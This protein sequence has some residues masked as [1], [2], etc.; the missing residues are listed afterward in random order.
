MMMNLKPGNFR[1]RIIGVYGRKI[2]AQLVPV[3]VDTPLVH[4]AGYVGTPAASRKKN[5]HQFFFTNGRYM[6]HPYFAKAVLTAFER[7]IGEG[8]QVPFFLNFEVA[9][10]HIDVNI[11]PT[12]TEIK[13]E[14]DAAIWQILLAAI[15]ESLNKSGVVPTIDFNTESRPD[16]PAFNPTTDNVRMP[17][18]HVN[19]SFNPFDTS[20]EENN[21]ACATTPHPDSE[22]SETF[23]SRA[24]KN[25]NAS[26]TTNLHNWQAA[27]DFPQETASPS[28][29]TIP[30][31]YTALPEEQQAPWVENSH[32]NNCLQ[33]KGRY[34]ITTMKSGI[35]VVDFHHASMRIQYDRYIDMLRQHSATSQRLLFPQVFTIA[36]SEQPLF[37]TLLPTLTEIGFDLSPSAVPTI[38]SSL[39]H[40]T[41]G[42]DPLMLL[43]QILHDAIE[44]ESNAAATVGHLIALTLARRVA[45][46]VGQ[47]LSQKEMATL[48]AALLASETPNLTPDGHPTLAMITEG[49]IEK[50]FK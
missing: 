27:Y 26:Q 46:P 36:P 14:D 45:M 7:L 16:I 4:I 11:H 29:D 40:G 20:A 28:E 6:R 15:R 10:A 23:T 30:L 12:K 9:P 33:Y 17:E 8:E 39:L 35:A 34:I 22:L 13:F 47:E 37:E 41:E 2:D 25:F 1:Q 24:G 42:I 32:T 43:S 44:G 31:L 38:L 50:L 19:P 49:Q 21:T 48:V 5:A 3:E 18:I